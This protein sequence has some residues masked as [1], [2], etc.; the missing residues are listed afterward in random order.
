MFNDTD[1]ETTALDDYKKDPV[2]LYG[3]V[4]PKCGR[5]NAPT[6]MTCDCSEPAA[7]ITFNTVQAN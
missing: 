6:K 3:W 7:V 2:M 1:V 5:V 4:C